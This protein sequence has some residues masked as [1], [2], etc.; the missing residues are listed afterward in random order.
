MR[1]LGLW[2]EQVGAYNMK[3]WKYEIIIKLILLYAQ[4][5]DKE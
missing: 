5:M 4:G 1:K 3:F 2:L